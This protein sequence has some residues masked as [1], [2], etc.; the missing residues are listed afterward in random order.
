MM[1]KMGAKQVKGVD[2]SSEMINI[3]KKEAQ[4]SNV[5]VDFLVDDCT[6]VKSY[7]EYDIVTAFLLHPYATTTYKQHV[8][9]KYKHK[10]RTLIT[11]N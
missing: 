9:S 11:D 5:D 6:K 3:A 1:K 4:N 8:L 7:G 2:I 10:K